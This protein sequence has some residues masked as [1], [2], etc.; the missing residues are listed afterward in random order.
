[1]LTRHKTA[2]NCHKAGHCTGDNMLTGHLIAM[3]CSIY[4]ADADHHGG[5]KVSVFVDYARS[6]LLCSKLVM[7]TP[8]QRA[9][10]KKRK[11]KRKAQVVDADPS[12]VHE[13]QATK[14]VQA[15]AEA[16]SGPPQS[17]LDNYNVRRSIRPGAGKGGRNTQLEKIGAILGAPSARNGQPKG[18]TTLH[19][20]VPA[21]PLA[22]EPP[23]KGRRGRPKASLLCV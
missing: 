5:I 16:L 9:S 22:P 15:P 1:M 4:T 12:I 3:E 20:D 14:K 11:P 10:P 7:P 23:C 2:E 19:S 17:T 21:N 6:L 13:G 18:S 8:S